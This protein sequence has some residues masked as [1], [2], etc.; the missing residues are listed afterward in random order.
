MDFSEESLNE[1]RV[2]T[3]KQVKTKKKNKKI[4]RGSTR[5]REVE[6]GKACTVLLDSQKDRN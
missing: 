6:D 5:K 4:E 2:Q 1:R 3:N